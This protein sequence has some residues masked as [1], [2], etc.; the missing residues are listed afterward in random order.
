MTKEVKLKP[1]TK[2]EAVEK[3][4]TNEE[5]VQGLSQEEINIENSKKLRKL[6]KGLSHTDLVGFI[7]LFNDHKSKKV[8]VFSSID[9][10]V[11]QFV[12]LAH[13][14]YIDQYDQIINQVLTTR[15]IERMKQ[16]VPKVLDSVA[17]PQQIEAHGNE[18]GGEEQSTEDTPSTEDGK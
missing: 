14:G 12:A 11:S 9:Q 5:I 7:V 6:L 1:L 16:G 13:G 17:P 18:E 2:E 3:E 10:A 8:G 4:V 15:T